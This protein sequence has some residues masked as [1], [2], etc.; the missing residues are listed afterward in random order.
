MDGWNAQVKS[1]DIETGERDS[2]GRIHSEVSE[3]TGNPDFIDMDGLN[4]INLEDD[5]EDEDGT[6]ATPNRNEAELETGEN[7]RA[8][9][10]PV[11]KQN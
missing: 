2:A 7:D 9:R 8:P 1:F 3:N 10:S 4:S 5:D 11:R 6:I